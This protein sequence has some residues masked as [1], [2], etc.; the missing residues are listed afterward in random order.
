MED[1]IF[2]DNLYKGSERVYE[3]LFNHL[4]ITTSRY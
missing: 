2:K 3:S 4:L 1:N